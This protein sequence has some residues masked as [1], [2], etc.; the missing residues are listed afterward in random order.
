[1]SGQG[2]T[3]SP[4]AMRELG[5]QMFAAGVNPREVFLASAEVG[6]PGEMP[7]L[8]QMEAMV[9]SGQMTPEQLEMAKEYMQG[10][11]EHMG[12]GGFEPM[13]PGG[14]EMQ[15]MSPMEAFE[16]MAGAMGEYATPEQM[17]QYRE[18][19]E[20]Y[21]KEFENQNYDNTQFQQFENFQPTPGGEVLVAVHD[22]T[23]DGFP[24]EYHYDTNGDMIA[25]HAHS[26][27]H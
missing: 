14:M 4:E 16:Q 23:A 17:E 5:E 9:A 10:G 20:T 2:E 6:G 3:L 22:H 13:G 26:T 24:D 25:D 27:P 1:M 7:N 18:M 8:E 12:P 15:G 11:M 19:A 21:Q